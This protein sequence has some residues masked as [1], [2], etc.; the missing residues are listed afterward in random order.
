MSECEPAPDAPVD[1]TQQP[2]ALGRVEG[3]DDEQLDGLPDLVAG[4][5]GAV[6][7]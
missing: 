3:V 5:V 1:V 4:R 6:G 7:A 2:I